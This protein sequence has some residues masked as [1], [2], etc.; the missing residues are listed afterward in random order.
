MKLVLIGEAPGRESIR[1][2]PSLALTGSSGK[3]LC[4][5]AGWDWLDYLRLTER[6]NLFLDPQPRWNA[7][8]AI[9]SAHELELMLEGR[10]IILLGAKV[11]EA[12]DASRDPLYTW[13]H[14]D[15][16]DVARIPHPS[17]RNRVWNSGAERRQASEFLRFLLLEASS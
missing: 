11:A 15:W 3:A 14:F 6:Y 13:L 2:R 8:A 5:I 17:G 10:S 1:E 7:A 16:A 4:A 12:F 9:D